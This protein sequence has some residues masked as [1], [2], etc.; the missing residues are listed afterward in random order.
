M[1]S[2][3]PTPSPSVQPLPDEAYAR[4]ALILRLGLGISLAILGG[5]LVAYI[6]AYPGASSSSI[7][8]TNPI[9]GYLSLGGLAAGLARGSIEAVLTLGL[10]ALIAVPVVRVLTG[11]YYFRR[12][13]EREMTA[14][15]FAVFALLLIGLLVI[16]PYVR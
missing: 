6:L 4:M 3:A 12:A 2:T 8:S 15:T 7:L 11:L 14:I 10:I 1:S 5:G 9:L 16:G 13:G